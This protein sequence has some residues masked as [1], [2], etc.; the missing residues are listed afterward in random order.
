MFLKTKIAPPMIVR[1][2]ECIG[3][4]SSLRELHMR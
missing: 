1:R 2:I 4:K 3:V